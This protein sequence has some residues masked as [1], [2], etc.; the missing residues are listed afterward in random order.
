ME[1]ILFLAHTEENGLLSKVALETLHA[2]VDFKKKIN[3]SKLVVGLFGATTAQALQSIGGCGLRNFMK[4]QELI[5]HNPAMD[6]TRP[7]LRRS[8]APP[9][10]RSF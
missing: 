4:S 8:S 5:S 7:P 3:G 6:R 2:A 9:R 10:R 1:N